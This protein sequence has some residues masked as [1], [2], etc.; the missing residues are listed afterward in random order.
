VSSW[1]EA[2]RCIRRKGYG[3]C[4]A[5]AEVKVKA[6]K[7]RQGCNCCCKREVLLGEFL[8]NKSFRCETR[9]RG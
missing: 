9:E 5:E 2:S 7:G 1:G 6:K 8:K 3:Y 4:I